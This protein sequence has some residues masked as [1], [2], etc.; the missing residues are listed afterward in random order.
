M[1]TRA[2]SGVFGSRFERARRGVVLEHLLDG[3][4]AELVVGHDRGGPQDGH[5]DLVAPRPPLGREP[6]DIGP[7]DGPTEVGVG[8]DRGVLGDGNRVGRPC[9]VDHRARQ[10]DHLAHRGG[11]RKVLIPQENE[12]DIREIPTSIQKQVQIVMVEHMDQVLAEALTETVPLST[13][14]AGGDYA[15]GAEEPVRH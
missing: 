9:A 2:C 11:I 7:P 5:R 10:H 14:P 1:A 8:P 3:Q 6:F 12:K 15:A 13:I 4:C